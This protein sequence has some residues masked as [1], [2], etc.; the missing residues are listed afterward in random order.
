MNN[1]NAWKF[2]KRFGVGTITKVLCLTVELLW[3]IP[4]LRRLAYRLM[5]VVYSICVKT[6]NKCLIDWA[7]GC[8]SDI[9]Y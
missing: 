2:I 7:K 8:L 3:D 4:F 6:N 5:V 9:D 1:F